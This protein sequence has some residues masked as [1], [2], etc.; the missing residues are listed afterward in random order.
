MDVQT[1]VNLRHQAIQTPSNLT[2]CSQTGFERDEH[3][4][5]LKIVLII[6]RVKTIYALSRNK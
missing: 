3:T 2:L 5:A 4:Y 6:L 1:G